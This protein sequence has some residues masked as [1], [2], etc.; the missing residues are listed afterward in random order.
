MEIRHVL[1]HARDC[2]AK[3]LA[4]E[5]VRGKPDAVMLID[6]LLNGD[7]VSMDDFRAK[8]LVEQLDFIERIDRL[9]AIAES[10]RNASLREIHRHRVFLAETLRASVPVCSNPALSAEVETL[11]REIAGPKAKT[12]TQ[13]LARQVAEAQI[14]LRRVRYAR[15]RFLSDALSD[16]HYDSHANARKKLNLIG[17]LLGCKAPEMSIEEAKQLLA[18]DRY[19]RRA[20]SRRKFAI[21][22]FDAAQRQAGSARGSRA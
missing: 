5:Y 16:Q 2:K 8:A 11:A 15:H 19:E 12:E 21:R 3:E 18:M 17:H 20:L 9:T 4:Q 7:G 10:R 22:A 1:D 14:D 13:D 6:N